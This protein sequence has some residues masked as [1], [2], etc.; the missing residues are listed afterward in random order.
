[1]VAEALRSSDGVSGVIELT[2]ESFDRLRLDL[3]P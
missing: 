3:D 2:T 1:M